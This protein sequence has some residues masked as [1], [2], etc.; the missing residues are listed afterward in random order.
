MKMKMKAQVLKARIIRSDRED[1]EEEETIVEV[2]VVEI[3]KVIEKSKEM[4]IVVPDKNIK[5]KTPILMLMIKIKMMKN[6]M[7]MKKEVKITEEVN[8]VRSHVMILKEVVGAEVARANVEEQI[9][10][11]TIETQAYEHM[12]MSKSS[13]KENKRTK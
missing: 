1:V 13:I 5:S 8:S 12:M 10:R 9:I 11:L 2:I 7:I 3:G 6:I 4:M